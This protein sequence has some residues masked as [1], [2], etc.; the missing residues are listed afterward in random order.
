MRAEYANPSI[1]SVGGRIPI[2]ILSIIVLCI[3]DN[4]PIAPGLFDLHVGVRADSLA[5]LLKLLM[6]PYGHPMLV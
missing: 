3:D 6:Q 5:M 4:C 2:V 1:A